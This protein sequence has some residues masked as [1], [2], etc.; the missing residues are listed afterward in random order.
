[1]TITHTLSF[2]VCSQALAAAL[3]A[4][5]FDI[6]D[7]L[8]SFAVKDVALPVASRLEHCIFRSTT[9][10]EHSTLDSPCL[11]LIAASSTDFEPI[12]CLQELQTAHKPR[13]FRTVSCPSRA[14]GARDLLA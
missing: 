11:L 7:T 4:A 13:S 10:A 5:D 2:L 3:K 8:N 6:P 1:M 9:F 12:Q 14:A